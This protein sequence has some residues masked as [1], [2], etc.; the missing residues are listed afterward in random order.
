MK[1]NKSAQGRYQ[2][3]LLFD[4]IVFCIQKELFQPLCIEDDAL[5]LRQS[6]L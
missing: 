2:M 6:M 4:D 1:S 3:K 5:I